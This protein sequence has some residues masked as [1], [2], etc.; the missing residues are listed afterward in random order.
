MGS[1]LNQY[2]NQDFMG[3]EGFVWWYGVVEDRKDP[4]FLGRVKVRC[5]G[6]H[7]DD[8]E[9]I[10]TED[11]PWAEVIQPITSAAISGVGQSPTGLVEGTHVFGFFRDGAEGQEPVVLGSSGGIPE[12]FSNPSRGFYDPRDLNERR[13][14]PY[15]P[16]AIDRSNTGKKAE[17]IDHRQFYESSGGVYDF[18]GP[19]PF[20]NSRLT[21]SRNDDK[22]QA[23]I[24]EI[25]ETDTSDPESAEGTGSTKKPKVLLQSQVFSRHPDENRVYLGKANVP[26]LSLPSTTL[27]S[28]QRIKFKK[29]N[30][31]KDQVSTVNPIAEAQKYTHR[32]TGVLEETQIQLHSGVKKASNEKEWS[33]PSGYIRPEYPYNHITYTESGHL[34]ELDDT[35][36]YER[37]RLLHRS[38]S[39]LEFTNDGSKIENVVGESYVLCDS[40]IFKHIYGDE[41]KNV[42]GRMNHLYNTNREGKS[43]LSFASGGLDM[44]FLGA[45]DYNIALSEGQMTVKARNIIFEGTGSGAGDNQIILKNIAIVNDTST[46]TVRTKSAAEFHETKGSFGVSSGDVE[47]VS[48]GSTKMNS[49]DSVQITTNNEYDVV[50]QAKLKHICQVGDAILESTAKK[51]ALNVGPEGVEGHLQIQPTG[52]SQVQRAGDIKVEAT[53]GSYASKL[54]NAFEVD[55]K[56]KVE[57][58]TTKSKLV[59][60]TSGKVNLVGTGSDLYTLLKKFIQ[61]SAT[62]TYATGTGPTTTA[63]GEP[64]KA[65]EQELDAFMEK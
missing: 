46:N 1:L 53:V 23:N 2:S 36:E 20:R 15:P 57:I 58:K 22:I 24:K 27:L 10:K 45:G 50:A 43:N 21:F 54:G 25:I 19:G 30:G 64:F 41:I 34:F 9:L 42:K 47:M 26:I 52:M 38:Q 6:F 7:T 48:S 40:N 33:V 18:I 11:L 12:D 44:N 14:A 28:N 39:F 37:V 51:A 61:A 8:K 4:L 32:I 31:Q 63:I 62:A 59:M 13:N 49:T 17:I 3:M 29:K 56:N 55:A 35:P 65:I 16:L 5:I 60:G